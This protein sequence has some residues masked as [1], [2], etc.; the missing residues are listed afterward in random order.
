MFRLRTVRAKLVAL[1]SLSII[2]TLV[3]LGVLGWLMRKQLFDEAGSRVRSARRAYIGDLDDRITTLKL[4]AT[5]LADNPDVRRAIRDGDATAAS[6]EG[7]ELLALYPDADVVLLKKDGTIVASIGCDSE[8]VAQRSI[9]AS[10]R[11]GK[12]AEGLSGR[13]CG[14]ARDPTYLAARPT[15]D[16]AV[17]VGFRFTA[18]RLQATGKKVGLELA[19][20]NAKGELVHKTSGFPAGGESVVLK[21]RRLIELDD[22]TFVL[23]SFTDDRLTT[24]R[25]NAYR[26]VAARNV[27]RLKTRLYENLTIAL[28]IVLIAGFVAIAWGIRS[29][30]VMSSALR[31]VSSALE[32]L[33]QQEYVKVHGV[34]T[35]DELEDLASG[36][37]TMVDGL[38]ERD[39]LKTTFGKYMTE[40]VVDHLMAGKVQLGGEMLTATILFSDIR[41]FTSISEKMDARSLVALLNE[42]FTEMVDEI[43]E[44]DG[45]V[46]KYIGDAIMAVFGAP[47]AKPDTALRAVRAAI[48]MRQALVRLNE[49]LV[50]RGMKP[51]ETGIGIH[52]GELVA[53]NIGSEKRMEYTVIGDTVNLASRLEG[54]TK[55]LG[56]SVLISQDTYELVKDHVEVRPVKEITVKGREQPVMTYEVLSSRGSAG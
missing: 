23:E 54:A 45:V 9:I 17:V 22:K 51:I 10:A 48:G 18:D 41:S 11:A 36:F 3:M 39:K 27:T 44:Q 37:N 38:Q 19:M 31:R 8:T 13:G 1:A 35:G 32:R 42:Y 46:D 20:I 52:T 14:A 28:G 5:L 40:A 30:R 6:N 55:E 15:E 56:V 29:A 25:G 24:G 49:R 53:G 34:R 33:K 43:I 12:A 4:A 2:V 47:V 50:A 7:K 26:L 21:E 16:G